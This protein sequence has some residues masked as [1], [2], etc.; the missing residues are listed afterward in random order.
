ME[1]EGGAEHRVPWLGTKRALWIRNGHVSILQISSWCPRR[2]RGR[3]H[4]VN[5]AI[6]GVTQFTAGTVTFATVL[7]VHQDH[8]AFAAL[9]LRP[10]W[11]LWPQWTGFCP[12]YRWFDYIQSGVSRDRR[13]RSPTAHGTFLYLSP[14]LRTRNVRFSSLGVPVRSYSGYFSRLVAASVCCVQGAIKA[15]V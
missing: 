3:R 1:R 8:H 15:P 12:A 4:H 2:R 6:V 14:R 7:P 11:R 9:K 13:S 10:C 5:G